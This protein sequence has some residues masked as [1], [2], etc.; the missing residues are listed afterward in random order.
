MTAHGSSEMA[1]EAMR[2]GA[3]DFLTKP[4]SK[5]QLD[6]MLSKWAPVTAADGR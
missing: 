6:K 3:F 4:V 5:D 2:Q 1:V